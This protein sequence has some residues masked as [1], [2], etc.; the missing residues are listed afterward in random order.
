VELT[1][2]EEIAR[3]LAVKPSTV[4]KWAELGQIPCIKMNG[5]L[6]FDVEDVLAWVKTCKKDAD[7]GYNPFA[8]TTRGP[9]KEGRN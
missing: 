6:R 1:C 9:G 2:V 4:Y 3:L 8:Q 5:A 7:S